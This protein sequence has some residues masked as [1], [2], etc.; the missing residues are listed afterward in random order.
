[1]SQL[2]RAN[3]QPEE[4]HDNKQQTKGK[5][6]EEEEEEETVCNVLTFKVFVWQTNKHFLADEEFEGQ[7]VTSS[8]SAELVIVG[9]FLH[10]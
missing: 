3:I 5:E 4:K 2:Q 10:E 9:V 1:M 8:K 7:N 6:E